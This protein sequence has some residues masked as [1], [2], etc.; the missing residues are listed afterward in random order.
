MHTVNDIRDGFYAARNT[1]PDHAIKPY[2]LEVKIFDPTTLAYSFIDQNGT[3]PS[4]D[5]GTIYN[6]F[7]SGTDNFQSSCGQV[8]SYLRDQIIT[9][10]WRIILDNKQGKSGAILSKEECLKWLINNVLNKDGYYGV[11]LGCHSFTLVIFN[12][13]I[14][15][16]QGYMAVGV[17]GYNLT[18]DIQRNQKFTRVKFIE[19]LTKVMI[20]DDKENRL[21]A[22]ELFY[23]TCS[24]SANC[25][26]INNANLQVHQFLGGFPTVDDIRDRF[27]AASKINEAMWYKVSTWKVSDAATAKP[28]AIQVSNRLWT[29]DSHGFCQVCN[30]AVSKSHRHHCRIC[31]KLI[32]D[33]CTREKNVRVSADNGKQGSQKVCITCANFYP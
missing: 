7:S 2:E 3:F 13:D 30:A 5:M 17:T 20:G 23:G 27:V 10:E 15:I 21:A 33:T 28:G 14:K 18:T 32:C 25:E 24:P 4:H 16:Y 6:R 31:A 19:H 8:T 1:L 9:G 12:S 26:N 29:P 11:C 22:K